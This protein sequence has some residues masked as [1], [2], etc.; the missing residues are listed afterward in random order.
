MGFQLVP[1][2]VTYIVTLVF[3]VYFWYCVFCCHCHH[4][5]VCKKTRLRKDL[6]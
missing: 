4:S 6:L 2:S 1:K 5:R 3:C